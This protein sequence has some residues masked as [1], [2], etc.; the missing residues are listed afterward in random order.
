MAVFNV[1]FLNPKMRKRSGGGAG[2]SILVDELEI[3]EYELLGEDGYLS[4]GDYDD[5]IDIARK[6]S[7]NPALTA[8]QRSNFNVKVNKYTLAQ[9]TLERENKSSRDIQ[10]LKRDIQNEYAKDVLKYGNNPTA[11]L[12]GR[13]S[14]YLTYLQDLA[15]AI[16]VSESNGQDASEYYNE[17]IQAREEYIDKLN[18]METMD[19]FNPKSENPAPLPG[20]AAY[21]TTN[22]KGEIVDIDYRRIASKSGY[23]ETN[24]MI[25]GFSVYGKIN[26]KLDGKN[27]FLLGNKMFS[28]P[29]LMI[30]D[31]TNPF[32][33]KAQRLVADAEMLGESGMSVDRGTSYVNIE[34]EE[35]RVQ[36]YVPNGGWV[37][38]Q[39]GVLYKKREDGA[40]EKYLN[41][42]PKDLGISD[43]EMIPA[44]KEFEE[45]INKKSVETIDYTQKITP[46][47]EFNFNSP[48]VGVG[49]GG[50]SMSIESQATQPRP[51]VSRTKQPIE[52]ASTDAMD[53][54]KRTE[55]GTW[56][57]FKSFFKR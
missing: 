14:S 35:I 21:V 18:I 16:N 32:A 4:P 6:H 41:A 15:D 57:Y 51:S 36:S 24:G 42:T 44:P 17:F 55:K 7:N 25:N 26:H 20:Y 29:D 10:R 1:S 31:P 38:G 5:L 56:D 9:K 2:V 40:Y 53:T 34:P 50:A 54:A 3:K 52:R 13:K 47:R 30:P 28:A 43:N 23:A 8:S 33:S 12:K 27:Y 11:F 19:S 37:K 49:T 45:L 46:D 22:N 48:N 39:N